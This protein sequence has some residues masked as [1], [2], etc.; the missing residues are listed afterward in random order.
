MTKSKD[1]EGTHRNWLL[2]S[3]GV[4]LILCTG[5]LVYSAVVQHQRIT[6]LEKIAIGEIHPAPPEEG[7]KPGYNPNKFDAAAF[8]DVVRAELFGGFLTQDQV[9][10]H[11]VIGFGCG[12]FKL[13][14]QME[15]CA[16]VLATTYHE[17]ARTM[18]PIEEYYG[19]TARYAPWYG[20]GYVM[21]TWEDNYKRQQDKM[22]AYSNELDKY[23][24]P[25]Q[26]H[27]DWNNALVPS[28]SAIITVAGMRDGDFTGKKLSDYI[29]SSKVDFVNARRIV[30][31]TDKAETIAGYANI[32]VK[33]LQAGVDSAAEQQ[34]GDVGR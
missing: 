18:Q 29:N 9:D 4:I 28:T 33:A 7:T 11:Q 5:V 19:A 27:D 34:T 6:E 2:A 3:V 25:W 14:P 15:Q 17:T 22:G 16:Y 13:E 30:N 10:G 12:L 8:Y 1:L 24:I 32:Y 31:G 20:R 23:K 26:V 21:I